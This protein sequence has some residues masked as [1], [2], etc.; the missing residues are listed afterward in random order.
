MVWGD[1]IELSNA[2]TEVLENASQFTPSQGTITVRTSIQQESV[3][4]EIEDT[5]VGIPT[6]EIP[7]IFERFY[8]VDKERPT[9]RG[10]IGLGLSI[11]QK[12]IQA[13]KGLI[14][15]ESTVGE[16]SIFRILLPLR[17]Q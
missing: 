5:G 16:G 2:L 8:R 7:L 9:D 4:L 1:P 6:D 17:N 3:I 13:H 12:I 15:V 11:A 14:E 10:G